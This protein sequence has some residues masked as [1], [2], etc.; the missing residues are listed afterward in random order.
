VWCSGDLIAALGLKGDKGRNE[1]MF[2]FT[3]I[4]TRCAEIV[5]WQ[6]RASFDA[7]PISRPQVPNGLND[8][9]LGPR[10]GTD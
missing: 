4:A 8:R 2:R 3:P 6:L 9:T 10:D 1:H 5:D 7:S